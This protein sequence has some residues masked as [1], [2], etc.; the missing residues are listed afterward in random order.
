MNAL[1]RMTKA[2]MEQVKNPLPH[3]AT[4]EWKS[5][6]ITGAGVGVGV[7]AIGMVDGMSLG[8]AAS[9]AAIAVTITAVTVAAL[10]AA[11]GAYAGLKQDQWMMK[12]LEEKDAA[13]KEQEELKTRAKRTLA[14]G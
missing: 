7:F 10:A 13:K 1:T 4:H 5:L 14:L 9:G 11:N 3:L 8:V 12:R 6:S 2:A